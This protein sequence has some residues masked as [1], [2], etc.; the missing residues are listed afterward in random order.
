MS[1]LAPCP[2][3][4]AGRRWQQ[5]AVGI[6]AA[7]T[8]QLISCATTAAQDRPISSLSSPVGTMARQG[9]DGAT[10]SPWL[11]DA[12]AQYKAKFVIDGRVVD[13]VN[14]ITHSEGQGYAMLIAV[15]ASDRTTFDQIWRWTQRELYVRSDGLA[16]W[17]W[18]EAAKPHV[19]DPNNATDGA[20]LCHL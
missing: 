5:H 16:S 12:W 20:I 6:L 15:R 19:T 1:V 14:R 2:R 7:C 18:E 10:A 3:P 9:R 8:L 13:N 17:K 11:E 4:G